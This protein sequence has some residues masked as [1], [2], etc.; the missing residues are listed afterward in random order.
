MVSIREMLECIGSK[1]SGNISVNAHLFGFF[2]W[3]VPDHPAN[4]AQTNSVSLLD[5]AQALQ[6]DHVHINVIQVGRNNLDTDADRADA[7]QLCDFATFRA[8]EIF[9]ARNLGVGR[10]RWYHVDVTDDEATGLDI[11]DNAAEADELMD[12]W[13]VNNEGIDAFVVRDITANFL[14][15]AAA[16]PGSC[17]KDGDD[18]AVVAGELSRIGNPDGFARTFAH[19]IGHFLG[20]SHNHPPLPVGPCPTSTAARNN[21]MAQTGC[22]ITAAGSVLLTNG[23]GTTIRGH[24]SVQEAC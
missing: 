17:D 15:R 21:L 24:C 3:R 18:N 9:A 1:T 14:G 20:L 7:D 4:A 13:R 19:E 22:S 23:Q 2:Q 8:R 10:V 11:I 6:G 5:Q 12:G 16:I